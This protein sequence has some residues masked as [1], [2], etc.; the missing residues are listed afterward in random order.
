MENDFI[1]RVK[2]LTCKFNEKQ[3]GEFIAINDFS[4]DFKKNKIYFIIGNSGS[5][6]STLVTHFNGLLKSKKGNIYV[7][8]FEISE[9]SKKIKNAKK[10]RRLISMVFQFPEYQLFKTTIEKDISFGPIA[11]GIPK[12]KS[13][14]INESNLKKT[15]FKNYLDEIKIFFHLKE[16]YSSFDDF[17]I[18]TKAKYKFKIVNKKD[19]A[20]VVL[21]LKNTN[22]KKK[23]FFET[24]TPD[25]YSH[26]IAIKY[27]NMM[28]L[29]NEYLDR[30]PFELS[31]GQKRR[32]AIAGILAI[33]PK[34]LIF[35][36]PTAGLDPQG[37]HEMMEII[38]NA[39]KQ[40]QTVIVITHVMDQVLEI[41][42]EVIV[43]KD[44]KKLLSGE[45]YE[46]FTNPEL[47]QST[48]MEKPKIIETIDNLV[49]KDKRFVKLY[50]EKPRTVD[51]LVDAIEKI[52]GNNKSTSKKEIEK[53]R[54]K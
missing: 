14:E 4:Y 50:E 46:I 39:K 54:K 30:S 28:G 52:L 35:D 48:K 44:G 34:I 38:L 29:N 25:D 8:H 11:L 41:G 43:M 24:K 40:G 13:K 33:E 31:G 9:K 26:E 20:N 1:L 23:I 17:L 47:Y 45:P 22:W 51:E 18:K 6:K 36:E 21:I 53:Q 27:L 3:E 10:L 42:D 16:N 5:G 32:V 7:D 19:Y 37:E 2:N 15:L 12:I 49:S